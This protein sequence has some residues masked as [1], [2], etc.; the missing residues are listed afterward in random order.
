MF[1]RLLRQSAAV[2]LALGLV[3]DSA[4]AE[5]VLHWRM[6]SLLHPK[7]GEAGERLAE[8]EQRLSDDNFVIVV[9]DR[10]VLDQDT[11]DALNSGLFRAAWG[12]TAHYHREDAAHSRRS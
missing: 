4:V 8:T 2:A 10:L 3:V 6:N 7:L 11:F 5:E 12:S 1:F 9:H